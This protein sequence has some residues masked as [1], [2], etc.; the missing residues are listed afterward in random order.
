MTK[1]EHLGIPEGELEKA[2]EDWLSEN[3]KIVAVTKNDTGWV[4]EAEMPPEE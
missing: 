4:V 3:W 2:L 1:V